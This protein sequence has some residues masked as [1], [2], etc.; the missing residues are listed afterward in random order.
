MH[1]LIQFKR[2]QKR[3]EEQTLTEVG[4][5]NLSKRK[6]ILKQNLCMGKVRDEPIKK[7]E[8]IVKN[9]KKQIPPFLKSGK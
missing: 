1:R 9:I 2:S 4:F 7:L 6:N 8:E 5:E 3:V